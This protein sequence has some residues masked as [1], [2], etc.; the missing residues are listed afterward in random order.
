MPVSHIEGLKVKSQG[1]A[2]VAQL[3][4]AFADYREAYV[5]RNGVVR[6]EVLTR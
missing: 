6:G 5:K 2:I 4:K 3:E 1:L